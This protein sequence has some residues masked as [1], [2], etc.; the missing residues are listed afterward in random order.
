MKTNFE[1]MIKEMSELLKT[2][3]KAE[4][5][6]GKEFKLGQYNCV[7][8]LAIGMG[9]GGGEGMGESQKT[10]QGAGGMGGAGVGISPIGFLVSHNNDIRF[11]TV[12]APSAINTAFEKVPDL[13]TKYFESQKKEKAELV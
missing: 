12:Q 1:G 4:T 2:K 11:I 7:P 8:V 13:L 10:T 5:I 6:I 3:A 9:L